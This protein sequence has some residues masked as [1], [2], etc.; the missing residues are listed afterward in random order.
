MTRPRATLLASLLLVL[1][2][3]GL[4]AQATPPAEPEPIPA[5]VAA[6]PGRYDFPVDVEHYD[7]E[8]ALSDVADWIQGRARLDVTLTAPWDGDL[9]LDFSGLAVEGVTVDGAAVRF[10]HVNGILR[11]PVSGT[12]GA[13]R[14]VEIRYRGVPDDGLILGRTV[15]GQPSVFADNWP[16]RARFWF[17]AVDHPKDKATVSFTV[18]APAAWSVIAN[19]ELTGL[20]S[21]TPTA[22]FGPPASGA[23]RT[24]SWRS[25]VPL[26]VYTMVVGAADFRVDTVGLAA[27]GEG[28]ALA[29]SREDGCVAVTTWLFPESVDSAA[30]SFVRAAAM[31]DHFTDLIGPFPY[32]KL[33]NVQSS[34][35]FGGMENASAIFY[36]EGALASGR[37]I[38]GTVSHEI[39]HQ[40]FGD[41]VTEADWRHLW[42]SEGFATYFGAQFFEAADGVDDF[43]ARMEES[44]QRYLSSEDVS[45]PVV[46]DEERDLFA[47]LNRNNY[48]KG[49]WVLHMLRSVMGDDA[50]FRGIR[51]YYARFVHGTA[52]TDDLRQVMEEAHGAD[53][54][55]FFHQWLREPGYPVFRVEWE[56]DAEAGEARV[57]IH[58]EQPAE[59]PTFRVPLD[60]E[61]RLEGGAI[62]ERFDIT[63]PHEI[64]R[65]AAP[66]PP[67]DVVLDPDGWVLKGR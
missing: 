25:G 26:P 42:L 14:A 48:Q 15:H 22:R 34:T 62:R 64:V 56:W 11:V 19:G 65:V 29:S 59:W 55:W 52:L 50:F 45:R 3:P 5:G 12:A 35:R 61:L 27:C 9:T 1:P 24:W 43:R 44:R 46:V 40:W 7:V 23:R 31:V 38:E 37:N 47:L 67:L 2:A 20:P 21:A 16:D 32:E 66:S 4:R 57:V 58:Q 13:L 28:R 36:A 33:A 54:G 10:V 41:A 49:G 8:L 39:A 60:V 18:H 6:A 53:L 30:P 63:L 51:D 17:P